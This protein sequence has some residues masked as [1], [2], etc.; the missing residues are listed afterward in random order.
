MICQYIAECRGGGHFLPYADH[1][2]VEEWIHF[3]P[4]PEILL[5]VLSDILPEYFEQKRSVPRSLKGVH[6]KVLESIRLNQMR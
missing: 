5:I 4:S 1:E 6:K 2:I 3:A